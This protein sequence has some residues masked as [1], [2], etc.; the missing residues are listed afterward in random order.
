MMT[1][2]AGGA[3]KGAERRSQPLSPDLG[4]T[5]VGSAGDIPHRNVLFSRPR[6]RG[7]VLNADRDA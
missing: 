5:S 3:P 2:D 1:L 7:G 4:R 6:R